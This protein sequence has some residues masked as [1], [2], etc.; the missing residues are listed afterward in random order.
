MTRSSIYILLFVLPFLQFCATT[1]KHRPYEYGWVPKSYN[2]VRK[3]YE[4][5][6]QWLGC[7]SGETIAS[8]GAGNGVIEATIS[9]FQDSIDWYLQEIDTFKLY[10]F[11]QV[12]SYFENLR[13]AQ[14]N[15]KFRFVIGEEKETML[16]MGIYDRII[17]NNVYHELSD[18][19]AI[20]TDILN[21]LR[22]NGKLVIMEPM[23]KKKGD[24][25]A[26][27]KHLRL[28]EPDF[29]SQMDEFG[30]QLSNKKVGEKIS[31]LVFYTFQ[32][33]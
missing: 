11:E 31:F 7:K 19:Q 3:N 13:G 17:M 20:M 1:K 21:K 26:N 10:Q 14:L 23:A 6:S 27:C 16:P 33:K 18:P 4:D 25:H 32:P 22:P 12:K 8:V 5:Y 28:W 2:E 29:L 15:S 30:Y 24:L 9:C